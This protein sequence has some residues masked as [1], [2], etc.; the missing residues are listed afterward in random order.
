MSIEKHTSRPGWYYVKHYPRGRKFPAERTPVEGY[1]KAARLDQRLKELKLSPLGKLASRPTMA[2]IVDDYLQWVEKNKRPTTYRNKNYRLVKFIIP[3]LGHY[4][5]ADLS[6]STLDNYGKNLSPS[7]YRADLIHLKALISWMIKRNMAERMTWDP[8]LPTVEEQL[9]PLPSPEQI[10]AALN[11]VPYEQV[12]ML[13]WFALLTGLRPDEARR[14]EWEYY[15]GDCI[16][17]KKRKTGPPEMI[18]IPDSL[19]PW[20][21]AKQSTGYVFKSPKFISGN[22]PITSLH[23]IL[24]K[25]G[26]S[27]G[28]QISPVTLRHASAT[29]LLEITDNIHQVQ[30]H[31]RHTRVTTT[32]K[33]VRRLA[34]K[35]RHSVNLLEQTFKI[36][37]VPLDKTRKIK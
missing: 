8:E 21:E 2:T 31:L 27:V 30:K 3:A 9:K 14:L 32:E 13:F 18:P 34:D 33:Y 7:M 12:K 1:E 25:A 20:F 5:V 16:G 15:G 6:Q 37:H 26:K 11:A 29:Y 24:T 22:H 28:V 23:G 35:K 36:G 10:I 4:R 17:L 19:Q